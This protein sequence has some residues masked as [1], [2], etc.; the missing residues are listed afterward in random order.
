MSTPQQLGKNIQKQR[1]FLKISQRDL[2]ELSGI[3][4]RTIKS[5]EKGESNPTI[6]SLTRLLEPLGLKL[7]TEQRITND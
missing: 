7:V 2:A 1:R 3:S 5:I 4:L 6:A